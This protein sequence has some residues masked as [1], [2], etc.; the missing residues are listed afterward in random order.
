MVSLH[1]D[2]VPLPYRQALGSPNGDQPRC[3]AQH[4]GNPGRSDQETRGTYSH[5]SC[6]YCVVDVNLQSS[7]LWVGDSNIDLNTCA[8]HT[9]PQKACPVSGILIFPTWQTRKGPSQELP[10]PPR[11]WPCGRAINTCVRHR[12]THVAQKAA[13]SSPC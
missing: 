6:Q 4:H 11:A 1:S 5:A 10:Q 3:E 13:S 9:S 2:K 12:E 7:S 8:Q